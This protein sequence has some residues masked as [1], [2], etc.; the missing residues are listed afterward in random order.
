M[1]GELSVFLQQLINGLAVGS[2]YALLALGYTM[3]FGVLRAIVFWQSELFMLGALLCFVL[4]RWM[5]FTAG[6]SG[7]LVKQ[8]TPIEVAMGMAVMFIASALFATAVTLVL[9]RLIVRPLRGKPEGVSVITNL[10]GQLFL[11]YGAM[12]V[13]GM[14][15]YGFPRFMPVASIEIGG[16]VLTTLHVFIVGVAGILLLLLVYIVQKT[17]IGRAMRAVSEDWNMAA[18]LGVDVDRTIQTVFLLSASVAGATGLLWAMLY[19]QANFAM[20][21][22]TG[23][24]AWTAAVLG[25]VGN[26]TG[27]A[28][29]GIFLGL[30]E[31]LGTGYIQRFSGGLIG[32]EYR[33]SFSFIILVL[34]LIL[35]PQ[36]LFG[37]AVETRGK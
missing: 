22:M 19:R 17:D 20:G 1:S 21:T 8:P 12:A 36:G 9:E 35:R 18:I 29:G 24:K 25:G 37:E 16:A 26:V 28:L 15:P 3:V 31:S 33:D 2:T 13:F 23:I 5:G 10:G 7:T 27:S 30:V 32:S 11:R 14:R 6:Y 34:V 4:L